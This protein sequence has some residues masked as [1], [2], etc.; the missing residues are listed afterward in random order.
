M[1]TSL[2]DF[3]VLT[4]AVFFGTI[5]GEL[6]IGGIVLLGQIKTHKK[7]AKAIADMEKALSKKYEED[8][9]LIR[10]QAP[11]VEEILSTLR[12]A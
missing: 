6:A 12:K 3:V 10:A 5:L 2:L 1:V 11:V 9:D 4:L 7:R 8:D